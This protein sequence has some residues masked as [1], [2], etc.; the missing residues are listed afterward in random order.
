MINSN[1]KAQV[2][3]ETVIYTLIGLAVMGLILAGAT[4]KIN[5]RKDTILIEQS[6]ESL[7]NINEKI[8]EVQRAVGNRRAVDLK[9][10]KGKV[11]IDMD[12]SQIKWELESSCQYSELDYDVP[13]GVV[14]VR[15]EVG[16]PYK[17]TLSMNYST[18]FNF[19]GESTGV[20]EL[21]QAPT[22]YR[23]LIENEGISDTNCEEDN[24]LCI[25]FREA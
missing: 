22:H 16:N 17:V 7:G 25:G 3:V 19:N 12:N 1:K 4:P 6:I 8:Y 23:L 15:T 18:S 9:V 21:F 24:K 5:C 20:H 13:Y 14:T 2:W 11:L 10:G